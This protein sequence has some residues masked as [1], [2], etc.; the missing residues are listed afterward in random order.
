MRPHRKVFLAAIVLAQLWTAVPSATAFQRFT[1][2]AGVVI[3]TIDDD[4]IVSMF[5]SRPGTDITISVTRGTREKMQPRI[6]EVSP[7]A[8]PAGTSTV[9]KLKGENL[10]GAT[11]KFNVPGIDVKPY[12]G[13]AKSLD[14]PLSISASVPPGEINM[15]VTTPIG[16][17]TAK[18]K[19]TEFQIGGSGPTR[20][21]SSKQAVSTSAPT[22]CPEGMVG[23]G[24]ERGG[25]CIEIDRSFT[26]DAR[27]A[28]KACSVK[29]MRLCVV[30]ELQAACEQANAGKIDLNNMLGAWEISGTQIVKATPGE[31]ADY[32][33]GTLYAVLLGKSDCL[34]TFDFPIW[35][36]DQIVGRCCK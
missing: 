14:I 27:G 2:E 28:E 31:A 19:V 21:D 25:F 7:E 10:V 24:A 30:A 4:G 15:E 26:S 9:L 23:V 16:S 6:T 1:D 34:T 17:T 13:K 8:I 20:R 5:E 32:A 35:K 3:Y 33:A 29:G 12:A 11:V 36:R 18:F 22:N